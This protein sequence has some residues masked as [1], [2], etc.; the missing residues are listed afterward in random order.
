MRIVSILPG[1]TE[2]LAHILHPELFPTPPSLKAAR[3]WV[4]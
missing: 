3:P 4:G 2:I 1:A